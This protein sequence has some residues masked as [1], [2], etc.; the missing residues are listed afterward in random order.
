MILIDSLFEHLYIRIVDG[1]HPDNLSTR[2]VQQMPWTILLR[3]IHCFSS[4][5]TCT[6]KHLTLIVPDVYGVAANIYPTL[7]INPLSTLTKEKK[8]TN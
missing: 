8:K 5:T 7:S 3:D 6:C 4:F 2:S 1:L